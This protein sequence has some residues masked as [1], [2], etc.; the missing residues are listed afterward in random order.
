MERKWPWVSEVFH[1]KSRSWGK[2]TLHALIGTSLHRIAEGECSVAWGRLTK[3][4]AMLLK[5]F[6]V[7]YLELWY[8]SDPLLGTAIAQVT[9]HLTHST[10]QPGAHCQ[11]GP[12]AE[13]EGERTGLARLWGSP[14]T[15]RIRWVQHPP[16]SALYV[17]ARD[18]GKLINLFPTQQVLVFWDL[19]LLRK[20]YES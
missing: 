1:T 7:P 16:S 12:R 4:R 13:K 15:H 3:T 17:R 9:Y 14:I 5:N 8:F 18:L 6:P 20:E 10:V 19:V 11:A 2:T